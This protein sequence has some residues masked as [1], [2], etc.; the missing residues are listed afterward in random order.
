M[1][2]IILLD[3][4]KTDYEYISYIRNKLR[5]QIDS[6][7][8]QDKVSVEDIDPKHYFFAK[9][10]SI[11]DSYI[12]ISENFVAIMYREIQNCL[13]DCVELKGIV[14]INNE[15]FIFNN[16]SKTTGQIVLPITKLN[17]IVNRIIL[18]NFDY[19]LGNN[20][21][22]SIVQT[23]RRINTAPIIF[24]EKSINTG[25]NIA[26]YNQ[27]RKS[28]EKV[29]VIIPA[30]NAEPIIKESIE[31]VLN[32][33]HKDVILVVVNDCSTDSTA[34]IVREYSNV[35]LYNLPKN[36]GTYSAINYAL[37]CINDYDYFMIHGA[38]D[39]MY[40]D[41]VEKH[42]KKLT[43]SSK[44]LAS[45]SGYIRCYYGSDVVEQ[46][47]VFGD[48]MYMYS[49]RVFEKMGYYDSVRFGG[50]S[51]YAAR[52]LKCFGKSKVRSVGKILTKAYIM[53][54]DANLTTS[55]PLTGDIRNN[56]VLKFTL[57]HNEMFSQKNFLRKAFDNDFVSMNVASIPSREL[58]LRRT[59]ESV[60]NQCDIVN[61]FLNNYDYIPDYL[62]N[63]VKINVW[64]S[65]DYRD[66]GDAGKFFKSGETNGYFFTIDD[67]LEYPANYVETMINK[68]NEYKRK[69]IITCHGRTLIPGKI[70][71]Y[72]SSTSRLYQCHCLKEQKED[73]V[74][75]V[76]GTGVMCF[77]S[78]TIKVTFSDFLEP[79]MADIWMFKLS[80]EQKVGIISIA[81]SES[82]LHYLKGA[83]DQDT[84][85]SQHYNKDS[86]QTAVVNSFVNR[87]TPTK[88]KYKNLVPYLLGSKK[89]LPLVSVIIPYNKDRGYLEQ[90]IESIEKQ[91]YENIELILSC[92]D[93]T[94]GININ[95]GI[96][97][98]SG[99][100]IKYLSEDDILPENSI[101]DSLNTIMQG[102]FDFIHGNCE[103]FFDDGTVELHIPSIINPTKNDLIEKNILHGGS[104]MYNERVFFKYGLF[105]EDLWTAEEFEFNLR[106]LSAGARLG[107]C[108]SVLYKYRRHESQK[109]IATGPLDTEYQIRRMEVKEA[110]KNKYRDKF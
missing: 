59:I 79:N 106:I 80:Q 46:Q 42:I 40:K 92:S 21:I 5:W 100:Y 1:D 85:Y 107:Y 31:S 86:I 56:Y 97:V 25:S 87:F 8:L 13:E 17:P 83:N 91:T 2:W 3:S 62:L 109:S 4:G 99:K 81:H 11:I 34:K 66:K 45:V 41:N 26:I 74:V 82:W 29:L 12:D 35:I 38:D 77:H 70:Q 27:T 110:I 89:E 57:E 65:Q 30:Y 15:S 76:G 52:F 67:D 71:S 105:A 90:A 93:N 18:S 75:Q 64:R 47:T 63:N 43:E 6:N 95:N 54:N 28:K 53:P 61:V 58:I 48:S 98:S 55:I 88:P 84:I 60:I 32:Q 78:D 108:N 72:Y 69:F 44:Y 68:I 102:D 36:V 49:R 19:Y 73:Q 37:Y 104:L 103:N 7:N 96:K 51:E 33:T 22:S 101:I 39:I 14:N 10:V 23:I 50:D 94:V 20:N 9:Y 24:L 16:T